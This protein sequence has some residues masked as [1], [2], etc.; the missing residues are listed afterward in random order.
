MRAFEVCV[1]ESDGE[2]GWVGEGEGVY[3]CSM[4]CSVS[5]GRVSFSYAGY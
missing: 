5:V 3:S 1:S 2:E 4:P